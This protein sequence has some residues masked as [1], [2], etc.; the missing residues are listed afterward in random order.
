VADQDASI[1][2]YVLEAGRA[3]VVAVNKWDA[4]DT[5]QR[6]RLKSELDRKLHFLSFAKTHYISALN[7]TGL[8]ALMRSVD[9][10]FAAATRK[11]PTPK[12]TRAL[13]EAVEQQQPARRGPVRPKLRYAHQG[14]QNPPI[15]VI[16]GAALDAIQDTYRRYLEGWFREQF[17]LVGTP[18]RVEF[19]SGA[20]PYATAS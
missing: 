9:D 20:N 19:R 17:K 7:G 5:S 1:A 16:H 13:R 4:I 14:G 3:L 18:L 12:L 15:I 10:A 6:E 8:G 2:G 11:L